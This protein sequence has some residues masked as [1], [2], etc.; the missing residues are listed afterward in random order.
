MQ[1]R[2]YDVLVVGSG[3]AGIVAALMRETG[4][5]SRGID[6]RRVQ[7]AVGI[8]KTCASEYCDT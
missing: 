1:T 3:P 5:S 8:R 4:V 6:V 2:N 7:D